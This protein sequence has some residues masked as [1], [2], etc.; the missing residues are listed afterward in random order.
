MGSL[1]R[2]AAGWTGGQFSL[3]RATIALLAAASAAAPLSEQLR[4]RAI[5]LPEPQSELAFF[6]LSFLA[7]AL[8]VP[9]AL[10]L[11]RRVAAV[12]LIAVG[13]AQYSVAIPGRFTPLTEPAFWA[14]LALLAAFPPS[15]YGSVPA[16]GRTD[17]AGGWQ[18]S[19]RLRV[20]AWLALLGMWALSGLQLL[21]T[22]PAWSLGVWL[23]GLIGL[24]PLGAA[25]FWS[26]SLLGIAWLAAALLLPWGGPFDAWRV[27]L[28]PVQLLAASPAWIPP[29]GAGQAWVYYDGFCGLCHRSVRFLLA[30]DP[31]GARFRFA[32]LQGSRFEQ[33]IPPDVRRGL[34]DSLVWQDH[35]GTWATRSSG[36]VRI[37][38]SLGGCWRVGATLLALV[39]RPLRDSAYATIAAVRHRLFRR[40]EASCPILPPHLL[41][42]FDTSP[43]SSATP[44]ALQDGSSRHA[45]IADA[46]ESV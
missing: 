4:G 36:I 30:E 7:L 41:P 5:A 45:G 18:V 33:A 22:W 39:P 35:D 26:W 1:A 31:Q 17:P 32:P 37:G 20:S 43:G 15:P 9:L 38:Q 3:I 12:G 29:R 11:F 46:P 2:E 24:L 34:P 8:A 28:L 13:I 23:A 6:G 10:G 21:E 42:R 19:W 25:R 16:A 44:S 40:P 27:A 14:G